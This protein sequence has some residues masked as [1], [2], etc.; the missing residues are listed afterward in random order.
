MFA[1]L[2]N[3]IVVS[4]RERVSDLSLDSEFALGDSNALTPGDL[5]LVL[6]DGAMSYTDDRNNRGPSEGCSMATARMASAGATRCPP[7][8]VS[9]EPV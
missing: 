1:T 4:H 5:A 9:G 8:G 7:G 3:R 2:G 6:G